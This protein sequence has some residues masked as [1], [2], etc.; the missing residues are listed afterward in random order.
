LPKYVYRCE[1]CEQQYE[2]KHSINDRLDECL[3]CKFSGSMKRLPTS[4]F[5]ANKKLKK[6]SKAGD[7]LKQSIEE[8]KSDL[9]EE[10]GKLKDRDYDPN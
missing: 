8:F 3:G 6:P 1:Q 5:I 9:S 2:V 10:K 7:I 4:V